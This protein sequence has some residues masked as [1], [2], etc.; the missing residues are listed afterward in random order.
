MVLLQHLFGRVKLLAVAGAMGSHLCG[1][2]TLSAD[3]LQVFFDLHT[4]GTQYL[5]I[6]LRILDLGLPMLAALDLMA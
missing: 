2:R 5:R 4:A 1:S 3:L 6:L